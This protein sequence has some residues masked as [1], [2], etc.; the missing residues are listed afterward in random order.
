MSKGA[1][2][3][4]AR[5]KPH[6]APPVKADPRKQ[7][8]TIAQFATLAQES[9][10]AHKSLAT[11]MNKAVN[12]LWRNQQEIMRGLGSAEFNLRAHQRVLNAL[13]MELDLIHRTLMPAG[14]ESPVVMKDMEQEDHSVVRRIDWPH[15]HEQVEAEMKARQEAEKAVKEEAKRVAKA[16]DP[17]EEAPT[18]EPPVVPE[19][20]T[21]GAKEDGEPEYPDGAAIFS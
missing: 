5:N 18:P 13:A 14:V 19:S 12:E 21:V 9:Q 1:R 16:E 2:I 4:R 3:R 20:G 6:G 15:Y 11:Q 8:A 7:R 17:K 10:A